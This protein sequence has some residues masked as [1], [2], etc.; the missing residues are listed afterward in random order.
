MNSHAHLDPGLG[1]EQAVSNLATHNFRG[2]IR[3]LIADISHGGFVA[4]LAVDEVKFE[5]WYFDALWVKY[6][7]SL[8]LLS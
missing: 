2:E 7:A 4:I 1:G 3:K 5:C 8:A 6:I